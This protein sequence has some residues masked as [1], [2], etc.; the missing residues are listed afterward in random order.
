M[1]KI[2][3]EIRDEPVNTYGKRYKEKIAWI[4]R[5]NNFASFSKCVNVISREFYK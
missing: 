1:N 4:S 5:L 2:Q 3:T